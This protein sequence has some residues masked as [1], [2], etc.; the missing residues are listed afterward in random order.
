VI[1]TG[2]KLQSHI[3]AEFLGLTDTAAEKIETTLE[4]EFRLWFESTD[5]DIRRQ[6]NGYDL[7]ALAFLSPFLNG[8]VFVNMPRIRRAGSVYDLRLQFIEADRV[9]NQDLKSDTDMLSGGVE[10]DQHGAAVAYHVLRQHPGS[11]IAGRKFEW[12]RLPAFGARSGQRNVL[13]LFRVRRVGQTRGEPELAPVI[14][15]LKQ[16]GRYTE[17]ELMAAV[18][19]SFF[20]VFIKKNG[21][22]FG[23]MQPTSETGGSTSDKDYKMGSAAMLELGQDED[24]TIANPGRPNQAFDPFVLAI[25][26]QIGVALDLPY[27]VLIKH[28]QSSYSAAR[29]ALLEAWKAFSV[30]RQWIAMHFCQPVYEA[31]V[32]EAV[33]KGRVNLPGYLGGDPA[34][35]RAYH[36]AR[37]QGPG[38]G[39]IQELQEV[40]AAQARVDGGFSTIEMESAQMN[41]SDWYENNVQRSR[42]K[43]LRLANGLEVATAAPREDRPPPTDKEPE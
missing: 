20:T 19:G 42:E 13:H 2:L 41:G 17:S 8:D 7:Q 22:G 31:F 43:T 37:W 14:E 33:V 39:Q 23:P 38:R 11:H 30:R 25:L 36:G 35:Q 28:F 26:R 27:E 15:A 18:V 10:R 12:D 32:H 6:S 16:L 4:R 3:D 34:V 9:C 29:A 5:C 24:V 1:G 21:Q 40:E